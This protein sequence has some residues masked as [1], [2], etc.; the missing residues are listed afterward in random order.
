MSD[1]RLTFE[2]EL[3]NGPEFSGF[4]SQ[5]II[6]PDYAGMG[7]PNLDMGSTQMLPTI[8]TECVGAFPLYSRGDCDFVDMIED[9]FKGVAQS[10]PG[11]GPEY[12]SIHHGLN[13]YDF[14]GAIQKK[15]VT[16]DITISTVKFDLPTS[17]D[18][19]IIVA[20]RNSGTASM[21][22]TDSQGNPYTGLGSSPLGWDVEDAGPGLVGGANTLTITGSDVNSD[23]QIMEINGL[24]T[25]SGPVEATGTDGPIVG[26]A[27]ATN[28]PGEPCLIVAIV[29]AMDGAGSIQPAQ[30]PTHWKN[31]MVGVGRIF[32]MYR[33]VTIPGEYVFSVNPFFTG[34]WALVFKIFTNGSPVSWPKPVGDILD[35]QSLLLVRDQCRANSLMGSLTMDS[36]RKAVDWLNDIYQAANAAP[37]WSGF[38]L[39]SVP[40]S[41]V[42]A[43]GNGAIYNAPTSTGPLVDLIPD[44]FIAAPGQPTIKITRRAQVDTENLLQIQHPSRDSDYND[45]TTAQPEQ[46]TI[47]IYGGRKASPKVIRCIQNVAVARPVL[48]VAVRRQNYLR[49]TFKFTL[50]GKWQLLEAMDLVTLTDATIGLDHQPVRLTSVIENETYSLDCEAEEYQYAVNAPQEIQVGQPDPYVPDRNVVPALVNAPVL[51]EPVKQ[52][53]GFPTIDQLWAIVSNADVNY[54]GCQVYVSTDGGSSY[55]LF[56]T[57]TGNGVTGVTTQDW[58]AAADP[59]TTNTLKLNLSESRGELA[60]YDVAD[61]DNFVYPCWVDGGAGS[62]PYELMTYDVANLTGS[63]LYELDPTNGLRRSVYDAPTAGVGVDHPIDSRF[64]FIGQSTTGILKMDVQDSL[65]GVMLFLKFV[66]FNQFGAGNQNIADCVAYPFT[67]TGLTIAP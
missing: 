60:S 33:V 66:A 59:D 62:I 28:V 51:F 35:M 1:L 11:A 40:W 31:L 50:Q 30:P 52:L 13:C 19:T 49:N 26:T 54:G 12:S 32:S 38:S 6:Y 44:D 3:G 57:I 37:V 4:S 18:S 9:I 2:S 42:S 21:V 65:I 41:E 22:F 45:V 56:G 55:V 14:P 64:A 53:A 43:V 27:L 36:Q 46:S 48:G 39:K 63:F 20:A 61:K 24:D 5:Q 17:T 10:V 8:L 67:P 58:P 15:M 29:I 47:A 23:V 7:S 25:L 34:N 16:S